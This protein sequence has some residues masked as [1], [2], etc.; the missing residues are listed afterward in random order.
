VLSLINLGNNCFASGSWDKTI[1]V[2]DARYNCINTLR[3]DSVPFT[4]LFINENIFASGMYDGSIKLWQCNYNYT[5]IECFKTISQHVNKICSLAFSG[6]GCLVSSSRDMTIKVWDV[7]NDFSC[8]KTF[9]GNNTFKSILV[10]S[11]NRI[12]SAS[13]DTTIRLWNNN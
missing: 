11:D 5:V 1:K 6:T 3:I 12:V 7:Y 9:F 2:W 4:L 13:G 10:L 8:I